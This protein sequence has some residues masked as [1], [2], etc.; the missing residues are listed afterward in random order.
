[1]FQSGKATSLLDLAE[2]FIEFA[3]L[4]NANTQA[5]ILEDDRLQT[6]YGA[7]FKIPMKKW[8]DENDNVP[9]FYI[10]MNHTNVTQNTYSTYINHLGTPPKRVL[11]Y[12]DGG[13]WEKYNNSLNRM[14]DTGDY[15][16]SSRDSIPSQSTYIYTKYGSSNQEN[17]FRNTGEFIAISPH[18]LFDEHLWM[19]EQGGTACRADGTLNLM[20]GHMTVSPRTGSSYTASWSAR[21]YPMSRVPWLTISNEN[22]SIYKV[23]TYGIDYWFLKTDYMAIITF[24]IS[25]HGEDVDLYQ[26]IAFGMMENMIETSYMFP[27]FVAGGNIGISPD[28]FIYHPIHATCDAYKTGNSYD[29]DMRNLALSNSNL[30]HPTQE[31]GATVTNFMILSPQ[32]RW[33][34]ITAHTQTATVRSYFACPPRTCVP[35]W[36]LTLE[37]PND[38]LSFSNYNMMFPRLGRNAR[39]TIDTYTVNRPHN[40]HEYSSPLQKIIVFIADNLNYKENG[41]MGII[42]NVYSSWFKSLPCGEVTLSGKRYLSIPNGWESRFWFYP[43]H[44]G[45]IVNDEWESDV[46]RA[47]YEDRANVLKNYQICDRLLIPLEEGA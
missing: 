6:F 10:S 21:E 41:C 25:N 30:L 3:Q 47:R 34:Y 44:I 9:Y 13:S 33:K 42:P 43:Y 28:F 29:L 11:L 4:Y 40:T 14:Y 27:L 20:G 31:Y 1:M 19:D 46:I 32:G 17:I 18:T 15:V 7:T 39:Y 22:K 23:S 2:Q 45:E 26:S 24:R 12:G 37:E 16:A 35:S 8:K 5:W 36:G 38:D